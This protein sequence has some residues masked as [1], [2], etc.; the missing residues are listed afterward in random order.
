MQTFQTVLGSSFF[1]NCKWQYVAL[2]IKKAYSAPF[3]MGW[4]HGLL[5]LPYGDRFRRQRR[6]MQ[7][8]FN[9]QEVSMFR[10]TQESRVLGFLGELLDKPQDFREAVQRFRSSSHDQLLVLNLNLIHIIGWSLVQS[11]R[12]HM[13]ILCS[14]RMIRLWPYSNV[15]LLWLEKW[16]VSELR[17]LI[18]S[19]YVRMLNSL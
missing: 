4:S 3:S 14:P 10:P 6:L 2:G 1:V 15:L 5:F 13:D 19:R 18:S 17:L 8:Y 7:R 16:V 11:W 12:Q 9:T